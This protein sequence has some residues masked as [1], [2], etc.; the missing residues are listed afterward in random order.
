MIAFSLKEKKTAPSLP[1]LQPRPATGPVGSWDGI[2]TNRI[3]YA[4]H[5]SAQG[6]KVSTTNRYPNYNSKHFCLMMMRQTT[7]M[8]M[9]L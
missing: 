9:Y 1:F 7:L 4:C 2:T 6:V 8:K 5:H 3:V